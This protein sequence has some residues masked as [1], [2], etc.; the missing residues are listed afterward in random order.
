MHLFPPILEIGDEEGFVKEK[1]IFGRKSIG[2]GLTNAVCNVSDPLVIAID[3]E[4]GNGKTTFLK[5]WA[6]ELRKQ[7]IPVT[8]FDAFEHDYV[9]DAFTAI[10]GQIISLA[11]EKRKQND[12]TTK[13]FVESSVRAAKVLLRSGLKIGA[14]LATA[15]ALDAADLTNVGSEIAKE[16]SDLEDKYVGELLTK[17]KQEKQAIQSFRDALQELPSLLGSPK[18]QV[19]ALNNAPLIIMSR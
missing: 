16:V 9:E 2:D 8:F 6:G 14:K 7:G 10:A 1:D 17:Q 12:P 19:S 18:S 5:M 13:K 4:W 11:A 3:S 15:G